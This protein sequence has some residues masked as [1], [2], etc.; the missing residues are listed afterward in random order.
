MKQLWW[1]LV[2]WTTAASA[3]TGNATLNVHMQLERA[4]KI[5]HSIVANTPATVLGE[6]NF[7][8]VAVNFSG[9]VTTTLNN[10][11]GGL[12]LQCSE[13]TPVNIEFDA[14]LH[15]QH[16]PTPLQAAYYRAMGNGLDDYVA[17]NILNA[18]TH[19]VLKPGDS[20]AVNA[21]TTAQLLPFQGRAVHDGSDLAV[22]DYTDT[23]AVSIRF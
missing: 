12:L 2:L 23:V 16:V 10:A 18:T 17:Y 14:G 7:G 21:S 9:T 6:L 1:G 11:F 15:P 3:D 8:T 5:N 13:T 4:C 19:S 22:G 20:I